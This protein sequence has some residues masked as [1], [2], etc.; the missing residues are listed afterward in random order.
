MM[1][2]WLPIYFLTIFLTLGK[3]DGDRPPFK[4]KRNPP[5]TVWLKDSLYID[6]EPVTN[7]AYRDFLRFIEA[8][9]SP[10]TKDTLYKIPSYG[11][12]LQ[13]IFKYMKKVGWIKLI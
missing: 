9:Y 6:V 4:F 10:K 2:L 3:N 5:G 8:G 13:G 1:G 11:V 7:A 12:D